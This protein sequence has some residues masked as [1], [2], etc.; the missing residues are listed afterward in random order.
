MSYYFTGSPPPK[1]RARADCFE[2]DEDSADSDDSFNDPVLAEPSQITQAIMQRRGGSQCNE[3]TPAA[4]SFGGRNVSILTSPT[5]APASDC[6]T[7]GRKPF[8]RTATIGTPRRF[9]AQEKNDYHHNGQVLML[10]N[11]VENLEREKE[12]VAAATRDQ[13]IAKEKEHA[14]EMSRRDERIQELEAQIQSLRQENLQCSFQLHNVSLSGTVDLEMTGVNSTLP[15]GPLLHTKKVNFPRNDMRWKTVGRFGAAASVFGPSSTS[16]V[17]VDIC[18]RSFAHMPSQML[19]DPQGFDPVPRLSSA[20]PAFEKTAACTEDKE[21][22]VSRVAED[23]NVSTQRHE[24]IVSGITP[25]HFIDI[26]G[27]KL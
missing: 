23:W 21:C 2:E 10:K 20:T 7:S 3:N 1:K 6:A 17:G 14:S 13:L 9:N 25:Q 27:R 4:A 11:R 12:R 15:P 19:M 5:R 24:G 18:S 26:P 16:G 8:S 22:Q